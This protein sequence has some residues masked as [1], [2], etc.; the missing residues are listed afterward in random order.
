MV[1][2][3][4]YATG[5]E[6][7]SGEFN[8]SYYI[9]EKD[10]KFLNW[11]G[12]LLVE[13]MGMEDGDKAAKF[14]SMEGEPGDDVFYAKEIDKMIDV[15]ESYKPGKIT[16]KNG[17]RVDLFYGSKRVYLT[18][19]KSKGAREK[20]ADFILKSREWIKIEEVEALP[21]YAGKVAS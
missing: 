2:S 15:H 12:K 5:N 20:L 9:F 13:V 11:L 10:D 18:L 3:K 17:D 19:R 16:I 8:I 7:L 14:V 21:V 4:I 1:K 6:S